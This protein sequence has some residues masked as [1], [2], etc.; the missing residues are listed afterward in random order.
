MST[1]IPVL[2]EEVINYS[3]LESKTKP[4]ALDVTFGLGGHSKLLLSKY[5]NLNLVAI[6]KDNSTRIGSYEKLSKEFGKRIKSTK[7]CFSNLADL[8]SQIQEENVEEVIM[9]DLILADLG[10]S[11][12]QLDDPLRGLS[13]R[14]STSLDMRLDQSQKLT[15]D[16]VLNTYSERDLFLVFARG[17]VGLKSKALAKAVFSDRPIKD[18]KDFYNICNSVLRSKHGKSSDLATVPFQ[19]VRIEV[20]QEFEN[21]KKFLIEAIRRLNA[22]GRLLVISFH[23]LEDKIVAGIMRWWASNR[24][25]GIHPE[26][27]PLGVLLTKKAIK[28]SQE[29]I[30]RNSRSRSA[31]LRVFERN[32]NPIWLER[33]LTPNLN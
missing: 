31:L 19:A 27:A 29:E 1:H 10:I 3:R 23:S 30:S 12:V 17:G 8:E 28:P 16:E 11:S 9:F 25:K 2:S 7:L 20:N 22:N 6:D 24:A 13:F 21:L 18:S 26:D 33:K 5:P 32:D 15:A 14:N 4:L